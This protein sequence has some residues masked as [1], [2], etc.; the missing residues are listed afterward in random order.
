MIYWKNPELKYSAGILTILKWKKIEIRKQEKR[1]TS[2]V[3]HFL[4]MYTTIQSV[5]SI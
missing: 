4:W 2:E 3:S 1:F 5:F